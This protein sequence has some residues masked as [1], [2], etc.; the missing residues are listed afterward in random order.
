MPIPASPIWL[1]FA[2][3]KRCCGRPTGN[4]RTA[5][6]LGRICP[7]SGMGLLTSVVRK[8]PGGNELADSV[9]LVRRKRVLERIGN[10]E[11]RFTHIFNANK[12]K[13]AESR[14][15]AGS[16]LAATESVRRSLPPLFEELDAGSLLDAPCGDFNWIRHVPELTRLRYIGGDIVQPLIEK[17]RERYS[18]ASVTFEHL[19]IST[20]PLPD[21]DL[22]LCRDCLIHLSFDDIDRVLANFKCSSIRYWLLTT[23]RHVERNSDIPTGHCRMLNLER[24]PFRF[25]TPLRYVPD[26]DV[27]HTGKCLGLWER[28]Q[29][30][31]LILDRR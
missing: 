13:D 22:W 6:R 24:P 1:I 2:T 11:A 25:P 3:G 29:L 19:D 5:G 17:N 26:D 12:W 28:S 15:G 31:R 10:A 8:L 7:P 20:A 9:S 21:V 4:G 16:T 30:V 23:H 14:S 18:G 27:E